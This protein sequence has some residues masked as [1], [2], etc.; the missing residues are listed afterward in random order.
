VTIVE[1]GM[2]RLSDSME[3]ATVLSWLKR[4][5]ES[6]RRGEPLVEVETDKATMVYEAEADGIL[7]E[8]VVD[9]GGTARL[10]AP[11]ARLRVAGGAE[12]PPAPVPAP[13]AGAAAAGQTLPPASAGRSR[14]TPVAR[15]LAGELGIPLGR[16]SGTGP[17]G[18]IVRADLEAVAAAPRVGPD[19]PSGRGE[20]VELPHTAT[21]QTIASRMVESRSTI[22]DFTL[23]AEI[24]MDAAAQLREVLRADAAAPLPSFN[25]LVVRAAALALRDH[26]ALNASHAEGRTIRHGSINIGVAVATAEAL[27][28]PVIRAAD[29]KSVFELAAESI[30]LSTRA[31]ERSLSVAELSD[32]TFTISN[33]GMFGVRRFQAVINPPEAAI[34]AVGELAE[35]P[36]VRDGQL[37]AG[38]TMDV[39]LSCDHRLVYGAEAARFLRRLRELLER[40]ALLLIDRGSG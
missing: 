23:E 29:R 6:V 1:I 15:R 7:D 8:I 30:R 33:L 5:G 39:T 11:I 36:V 2:P 21:R 9:A 13:L 28:V 24:A 31:R 12:L 38:K 14:A 40:P 4:P 32:G 20:S 19:E 16:V 35:R 17:G 37:V 25:D 27:V 22:P 34:L 26:P 3:E 18:R 10:G